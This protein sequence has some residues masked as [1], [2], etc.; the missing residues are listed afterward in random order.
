MASDGTDRQTI[1][2]AIEI[3]GAAGQGTADWAPDGTEIVIGGRDEKGSALFLIPADGKP[4]RRLLEGKWV[5]PVW[6]PRGDMILYA[7][8]SLVGQVKLLAVNPKD[9]SSV[10]LP[11]VW[12]RPGG[13]RFLPDGRGVVYLPRIYALDFWLL[14]L[15]TKT[16]RQLTHF[17]N[18][19]AIRAF[20]ITPDGK[21]IVFDR[22]RQNSDV[23]LLDFNR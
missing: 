1:A 12:T 11:E 23:V 7:G 20:D 8:R 15:A 13:Y 17:T 16:T 5:N 22:V 4:P 18:Q 21:S 3:E 9:G 6:S 19:G 2:P 14:D 10:E